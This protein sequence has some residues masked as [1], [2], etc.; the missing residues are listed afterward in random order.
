[1][2]TTTQP[3]ISQPTT[4][5]SLVL[6]QTTTTHSLEVD[7]TIENEDIPGVDGS[8]SFVSDL[9]NVIPGIDR[10]KGVSELIV[11]EKDVNLGIVDLQNAGEKDDRL[12]DADGFGYTRAERS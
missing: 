10:K 3:T 9:A 11:A 5:H 1:M 7:P 4:T 8:D 2:P 6:T 12:M